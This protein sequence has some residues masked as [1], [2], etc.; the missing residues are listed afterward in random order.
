MWQDATKTK[1]DQIYE[2]STCASKG[3]GAPVPDGYTKIRVH[4]IYDIK[5]DGK[6]KARLV[7][8]G[9]LTGPNTDTYYSSVVSLR[10]MR[11]LV[12]LAEL[13]E[14]ELCASNIGNAY[15]EA[16]TKEKVCFIAGH[17]F[18]VYGQYGHM[19]VVV[20]AFYG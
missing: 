18:E 8:G 15:L 17:E 14:L 10:V 13:N 20:K 5:Q 3:K 4:L 2:Y 11:M 9:H 6:C 12:F 16:Y 1:M 19:M 7:A